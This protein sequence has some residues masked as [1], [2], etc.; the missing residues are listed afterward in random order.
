MLSQIKMLALLLVSLLLGCA[1]AVKHLD[2][3]W[4]DDKTY[5][6][7]EQLSPLEIPPELRENPQKFHPIPQGRKSVPPS[8]SPPTSERDEESPIL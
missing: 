4:A 2:S 3:T 8:A 5:P 7:S 6:K 1:A